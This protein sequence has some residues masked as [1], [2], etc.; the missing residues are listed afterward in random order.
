MIRDLTR[1]GFLAAGL[2]LA[3]CSAGGAGRSRSTSPSAS[4]IPDAGDLE[5]A[6]LEASLEEVLVTAHDAVL[7]A[8]ASGSLGRVPAAIGS[9]AA[10]ARQ[11]H[12]KHRDDINGLLVRHGQ[13][14]ASADPSVSAAV[15][16]G[17]A[18][19]RTA[20][21]A[22]ELLLRLETTAMET[23]VAAATAT[24]DPGLRLMGLT[25]APIEAQHAAILNLL[26]G[27]YPA[28]NAEI[29]GDLARHPADL[30]R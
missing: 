3:G 25:I 17:L 4:P 11:H 14:P 22:A 5:W 8:A 16:G 12:R 19:L 28:P 10:T 2:A 7:A 29:R 30:R 21:D 9:A 20:G 1:R 27:R 6:R 24:R 18:D 13:P 23:Y 15:A 26:L